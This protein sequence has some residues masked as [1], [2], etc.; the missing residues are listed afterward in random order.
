VLLARRINVDAAFLGHC[1][2]TAAAA[3]AQ[4][5]NRQQSQ[6]APPGRQ[7]AQAGSSSSSS[8]GSGGGSA[9][10]ATAGIASVISRLVE[11]DISD[12]VQLSAG[13][14][15]QVLHWGSSN[16]RK[17]GAS[18]CTTLAAAGGAD[19]LKAAVLLRKQQSATVIAAAVPEQQLQPAGPEAAAAAPAAACVP[20][21]LQL[22]VGW[23]WLSCSVAVLL[24]AS[25]F[26]TSFTAGESERTDMAV[27]A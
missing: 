8:G 18:G 17:L 5:Q 9:G 13:C 3:P 24:Q 23:G 10:I 20:Q 6:Q 4:L 25:A 14:L 11:L 12:A 26:L 1:S 22:S 21:L 16:L 19:A 7:N 27:A 2:T 15:L